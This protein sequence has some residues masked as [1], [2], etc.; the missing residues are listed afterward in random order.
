MSRHPA[1]DM[2]Q[3]DTGVCKFCIPDDRIGIWRKVADLLEQARCSEWHA[4]LGQAMHL[5]CHGG[6][7][8][9]H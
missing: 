7:L 2:G 1:Q 8:W 4:L 3:L 6:L 9:V 5:Q